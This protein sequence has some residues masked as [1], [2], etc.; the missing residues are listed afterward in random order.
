MVASALLIGSVLSSSP[1]AAG[2]P[3]FP[4]SEAQWK[5]MSAV[6]QEAVMDYLRSEL[7]QRLADGSAKFQ[8][9]SHSGAV[10]YSAR[11]SGLV[12]G[13][14]AVASVT[15]SYQCYIRWTTIPGEG[16]WVYGGGWTAASTTVDRIYAGWAGR[17]GKF[18]RDGAL[19][20]NWWR[21]NP[22]NTYAENWTNSHWAFWWETPHWVTQGWH[23][24]YDNGRWILGPERYCF[25]EQWL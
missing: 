24:V 14:D 20:A 11:E 19:K 16:D 7:E 2:N 13:S 21:D 22:N 5:A 9:V 10:T 17:Q 3:P 25:V 8:E 12:E 23:G 18:L 15:A 4:Q 6:E 1:T